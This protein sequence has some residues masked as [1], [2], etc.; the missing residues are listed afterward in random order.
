VLVRRSD[1]LW[2]YALAVV[3]DDAAMGIT[4][5]VRGD[6]LWDA[7]G[8]QLALARALGHPAPRYGHV[9][10]LLDA[11]GE[12]MAKRRGASTL[13]AYRAEGLDPRR[14]V[15]ALA[16][17]AGLLG[18]PRPLHPRELLPGFDLTR[19]DPA[20]ARWTDALEAWVRAA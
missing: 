18:G 14:L 19:L 12:R 2:A 5:V 10:L 15:G 6:D 4:E 9:P 8:A 11:A 17:T 1:G 3:V 7:T 16:A 13:A 20:P